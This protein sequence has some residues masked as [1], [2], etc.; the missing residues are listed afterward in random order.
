KCRGGC[1]LN[2]SQAQVHEHW[3]TTWVRNGRGI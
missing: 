1:V 3:N 2:S